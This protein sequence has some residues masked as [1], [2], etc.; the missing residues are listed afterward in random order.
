MR[1]AST[2]TSAAR[3]ASTKWGPSIAIEPSGDSAPASAARK[4]FSQRLS[5]LEISSGE[6]GCREPGEPG[7]LDRMLRAAFIFSSLAKRLVV[8]KERAWLLR[9]AGGYGSVLNLMGSGHAAEFIAHLCV[10]AQ[11]NK[12][13]KLCLLS[14]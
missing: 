14:F 2:R 8:V 4:P 5:R 10:A 7:E 1:M 11:R 3:D 9:G 12:A 13:K 6:R